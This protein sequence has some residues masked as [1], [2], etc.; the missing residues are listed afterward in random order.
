M[1]NKSFKEYCD[2]LLMKNEEYEMGMKVL[3]LF[4]GYDAHDCAIILSRMKQ[5]VQSQYLIKE[6][7]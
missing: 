7:L 2:D 4:K 3:N 6:K 1:T 5:Y